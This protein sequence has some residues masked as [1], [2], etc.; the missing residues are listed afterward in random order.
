MIVQES[1]WV[2]LYDLLSRGLQKESFFPCP[3]GKF[4][5]CGRRQAHGSASAGSSGPTGQ[6]SGMLCQ[7]LVPPAASTHTAPRSHTLLHTSR[8]ENHNA[9]LQRD[10]SCAP[11][12]HAHPS[13]AA[14]F[15]LVSSPSILFF[16]APA[17]LEEE[18]EPFQSPF[19]Q[20]RKTKSP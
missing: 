9:I 8:G 7:G 18:S 4:P 6:D 5:L 12:T 10:K 11:A 19:S 2:K 20:G 14:C 15:H 3:F 17:R 16:P 13:F 1:R